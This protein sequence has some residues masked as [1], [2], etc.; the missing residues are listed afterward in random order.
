MGT[1]DRMKRIVH[2]A[3]AACLALSAGCAA[4]DEPTAETTA[5][6]A[7][8]TTAA[9]TTAADT[10]AADTTDTATPGVITV[11]AEQ[12]TIQAAVDA[13]QPGDLI[14]ISP[15]TYDE[16]I[17][18]TTDGLTIRQVDRNEVILDGEFEL[19]NGPATPSST[20][21]SASTTASA[22]RGPTPAATCSS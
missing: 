8:D 6:T 16:A 20:T 7:A 4:E 5:A 18:V 12:P 14:L 10:T 17:D 3:L 15:G 19:D 13:A 11:P 9:D 2:I 1:I 21:S 22:I